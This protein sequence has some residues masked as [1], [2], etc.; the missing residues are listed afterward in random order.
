MKMTMKTN[1]GEPDVDSTNL[2][3]NCPDCNNAIEIDYTPEFNAKK[4][5]E[6]VCYACGWFDSKR[7]ETRDEA[8]EPNDLK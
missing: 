6:R 1:S 8:G 4:P 3:G 5:F 7:Y 2:V